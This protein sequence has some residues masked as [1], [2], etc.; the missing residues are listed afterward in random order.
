MT[1]AIRRARRSDLDAIW[2]LVQR[3]VAGMRERGNDQ[4][5]DD[6]PTRAIYAADIERGVLWCA[7]DGE[8]GTVL[9]AAA[10][11]CDHE[12]DYVGVPFRCPEPAAAMH[13]MAVEPSAQRRG[14]A[15]ALFS[16][17]EREGSRLGVAALRI[18]TYSRND[19]MQALIIKQGFTYV[20]DTHMAKRPLAY[21]C[22][23]KLL[24]EDNS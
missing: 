13:R 22:Y 18:D 10:I 14:V 16:Q 1:T 7:E 11:T 12:P 6:Y 2:T 8:T 5:G 23:E 20:G 3:A 15:S 21:H 19:R 24:K 17:F 4:W 9:G